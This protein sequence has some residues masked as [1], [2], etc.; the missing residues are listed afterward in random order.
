MRS[1]EEYMIADGTTWSSR[2]T[3]SGTVVS[4]SMALDITLP[5]GR[6]LSIP[7]KPSSPGIWLGGLRLLRC[8]GG[9]YDVY[10]VEIAQDEEYLIHTA[11]YILR[12]D[13]QGTP[14]GVYAGEEAD[15]FYSARSDG[16][17]LYTMG[18][19]ETSVTVKRAPTSTPR[20][21]PIT[22]HRLPISP[23]SRNKNAEITPLSALKTAE[24]S[25]FLP[26]SA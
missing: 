20:P 19:D 24:R 9:E 18:V 16:G 25:F 3:G 14:L 21:G 6:E 12:V 1:T 4:D 15:Q 8:G 22:S 11:E 5:D 2:M 10:V 17:A 7:F 23:C 26:L 13:E